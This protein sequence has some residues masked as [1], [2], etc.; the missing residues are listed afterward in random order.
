MRIAHLSDLHFGD[1]KTLAEVERCTAFAIDAAVDAGAELAVI[2]GDS[3]DHAIDVHSPSFVVAGA[4]GA[5]ARRPLPGADAA[6]HV[7]ARAARHAGRVPAARRALSGARGRPHPAGG[8]VRRA[9]LGRER[10]LALRRAAGRRAGAVVV[11]ADRQQGDA[12][13]P[14]SAPHA[15]AEAVGQQL[16]ALLAGFGEINR[17][18]RRP[19]CRR[20]ACRTAR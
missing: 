9:G 13:P 6:R 1:P 11:R 5:P 10:R 12:W 15:A 3:T 16:A 8:V 14:R 17:K 18:P 20:S 19:A 4:P 2:S 7:L